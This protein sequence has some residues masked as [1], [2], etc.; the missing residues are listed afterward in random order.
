MIVPSNF[1]SP[2]FV[3]NFAAIGEN[4]T[5]FENGPLKWIDMPPAIDWP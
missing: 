4:V 3:W 5:P 1:Y 2:L